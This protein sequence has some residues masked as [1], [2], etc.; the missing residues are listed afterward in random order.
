MSNYYCDGSLDILGTFDFSFAPPLIFYSFIPTIIILLSLSFYIAYKDK[1]SLQSKLLILLAFAFSFWSFLEIFLWVTVPVNLNNFG[2]YLIPLFQ[3]LIPVFATFFALVFINSGRDIHFTYKVILSIPVILVSLF[4]P[5]N[6]NVDGFDVYLCE[7]NVG[8]LTYFVHIASFLLTFFLLFISLIKLFRFVNNKS[9]ERN[10]S[11]T[12]KQHL[13]VSVGTTIFLLIY[14]FGIFIGEETETYVLGLIAPVGM[15][16]LLVS[17]TYMIVKFKTFSIKLAAPVALVFGLWFLVLSLMF[18]HDPDVIQ[19]ILAV[20][21]FFL[22][23]FGIMLIRSVRKE[24]KQREEIQSLASSLAVANEKLKELDKLKSEFVSIASHQLRAP[25]TA[26]RGYASMLLDGSFGKMPADA[27]QALERIS[28]SAKNMAY[29][30][31]DYL[32]VSRI[33]SG[34][35]KYNYADFNLRDETEHVCDDLRPQ[36]LRKGL[37]LL[38]R[39]DLKSQGVINADVG[40]VIQIIQNL[41]NNSI[42]YTEKGSIKVLVRDDV[43]RKKIYVDIEDTGIGMNEETKSRLFGKFERAKNANEVN[44]GGT[45][46]GLYVAFAMAKGM[47]GNIT[48]HSE[49]DG[50]G[51]RFTIEFALAM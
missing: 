8:T 25:L 48:A 40:K 33:E 43:V 4:L 38:F 27:N 19:I 2:W 20:T 51:S 26:I 46:L 31:E 32:N 16:I 14:S 28:E 45:G 9:P 21:L 44:T 36:A 34:N 3:L 22:V 11:T 5:T 17:L 15:I 7:A 42:K 30:V 18:I 35:M 29:S 41:I 6:I 24:I 10:D 13:I 47:N 1:F 49:G 23:I 37:V 39:T 12:I 50:K